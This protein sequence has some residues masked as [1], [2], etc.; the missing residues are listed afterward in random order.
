MAIEN[1]PSPHPTSDEQKTPEIQI[2]FT[3]QQFEEL[4]Q[5]WGKLQVDALLKDGKTKNEVVKI[6]I[7]EV[8]SKADQA[9]I[10][11]LHGMGHS[12]VEIVLRLLSPSIP[13]GYSRGTD[14]PFPYRD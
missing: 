7:E 3:E 1:T 9:Y 14:I 11:T 12:E 5:G 4:R 6:I 8:V 2:V 10:N 13:R